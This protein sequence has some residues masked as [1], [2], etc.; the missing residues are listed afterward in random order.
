MISYSQ[1]K[2]LYRNVNFAKTQLRHVKVSLRK[3]SF[4]TKKTLTVII[5]IESTM[6]SHVRRRGRAGPSS[7][8]MIS[9]ISPELPREAFRTCRN[10]KIWYIEEPRK[11]LFPTD[12][13]SMQPRVFFVWK[14]PSWTLREEVDTKSRWKLSKSFRPPSRHY[15]RLRLV[16]IQNPFPKSRT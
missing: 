13:N 8:Y 11:I 3:F 9:P 14:I 1:C 6:I 7:Q 16:V 12:E 4:V 5:A 2:Y 10:F 15:F